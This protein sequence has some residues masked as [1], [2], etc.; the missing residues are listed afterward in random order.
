METIIKPVKPLRIDLQELWRYREL[1]YYLAWRDVKVRYKQTAIGVVW[2]VIQ[3]FLMMVVLSIF[4]GRVLAVQTNGIPY[5]IFAFTGLLFWNYFSNALTGASNSLVANQ[6]I[7]Q[8]IYFPRVLL[9]IASTMVYL[10]DFVIASFVLAGLMVYYHYAP[11]LTG[12]ILIAPCL[13]ITCLTFSGLGLWLAALNVKYRDVRYALPFFIQV[14]LF[15]TPVI[16]PITLLNKHRWIWLFNPMSGVVDTMRAGLLSVGTINW[17]LLGVSF[18]I[19]I[20]VF[21]FGLFYFNKTEH[22]F[23]DIV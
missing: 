5:P 1:F 6:A 10:L 15:V 8:K 17:Q 2:A 14:L 12:L 3:P 9:P 21:L 13:L 23:A 11:S 20:A 4:F 19:S 22:Y 18:G 16:Y 7:I